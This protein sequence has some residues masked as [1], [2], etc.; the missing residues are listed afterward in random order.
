MWIVILYV[1]AFLLALLASWILPGPEPGARLRV[2]LGWLSLAAYFLAEALG[3]V[4]ALR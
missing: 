2:H 3:R 1:L 4:G